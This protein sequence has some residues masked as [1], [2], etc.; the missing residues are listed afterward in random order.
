MIRR[1]LSLLLVLVGGTADHGWIINDDVPL[2]LNADLG[3]GFGVWP[4]P[5]QPWRSDL[6]RGGSVD[7]GDQ[8]GGARVITEQPEL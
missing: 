1:I 4:A 6:V 8:Q 5:V 3:E 7:P 2:D